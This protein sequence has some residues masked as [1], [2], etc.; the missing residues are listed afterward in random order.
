MRLTEQASGPVAN[1]PRQE[2]AWR[3][4]LVETVDRAVLSR[5]R[6]GRLRDVGWPSGLGI[7]VAVGCG[8]IGLGCLIALASGWLRATDS[9]LVSSDLSA[10]MPAHLVWVI[11][12]LVVVSLALGQAA[13]VH[14]PWW[15]ALIATLVTVLIMA[16][17]GLRGTLAGS[18]AVPAVD[19]GLIIAVIV[20]TVIRGRRSFAWWEF[21]LLL[22]LIGG[23]VVLGMAD[24]AR[25]G[26]FVGY[27]LVPSTVESAVVQLMVLVLPAA[28][29]AGT[30]VAELTVGLTVAAAAQLDRLPGR[31]W[32]YGL[33]VVLVLGRL[34]ELIWR[35]MQLDPVRQGWIAIVPA[36]A[37]LVLL[38]LV[39]AGLLRTAF[40]ARTRAAGSAGAD[41]AE[42]VVISELAEDLG[43]IAL[44]IGAALVG[45]LLPLF[46][47]V[48]GYSIAVAL[49][50]TGPLGAVDLD[51]GILI[52]EGTDLIRGAIAVVLLLIAVRAA[53]HA[54]AGRAVLLGAIAVSLVAVSMRGLTGG[55][56]AVRLD[57]DV[58]NLMVGIGALLMI[59]WYAA[60]RRLT[61]R[62]AVAGSALL[63]LSLLFAA[64]Q[65]LG[66]PV[67]ALV[68]YSGVG[69][70]VLGMLWDFLTS[71]DWANRESPRF[72]RPTRVLLVLT[73]TG[74]LAVVVAYASLVRDSTGTYDPGGFAELGDLILGTGLVAAAAAVVVRVL[75]RDERIR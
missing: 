66:D 1:G 59:G 34:A 16:Q 37:V 22:G 28:V 5:I 32:T 70:V 56:W 18:L 12:L 9:L 72:P 14:G 47:A 58:L 30:A 68:G 25:Q 74:L 65:V 38:A 13:A 46:V 63:M 20:V 15:L 48:T 60:R 2:R 44:P 67:G 75:I 40:R 61:P 62:R 51:L 73:N 41:S 33:L 43:R 54:R 39:I 11:A 29:A 7:V 26:R 27:E 49:D 55:R 53:R 42:P 8:V 10:S 6:D 21:P 64:R 31:W 24:L 3:R 45:L 57:P 50:P 19:V 4:L 52:S 17:F 69:L 35:A 71:A 36:A 23:A